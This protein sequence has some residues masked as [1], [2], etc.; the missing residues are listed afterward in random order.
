MPN[1]LGGNRCTMATKSDNN[2]APYSWIDPQTTWCASSGS[3]TLGSSGYGSC[4]GLVLYDPVGK[5]GA[6]AHFPGS[7]GAVQ[8]AETVKTDADEILN[9]V[10]PAPVQAKWYAWIFGG[11]SLTG[12]SQFDQA[13]LVRPKR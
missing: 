7:Y 1:H 11:E 12:G 8:H 13:P 2:T 10:C 9:D 4:V 6:V 5:A 3:G